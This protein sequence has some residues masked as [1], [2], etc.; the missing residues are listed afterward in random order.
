MNGKRA[1]VIEWSTTHPED[2]QQE[3]RPAPLPSADAVIYELHLRDFSTGPASGIRYRGKYLAFT[4]EHTYNREGKSTGIDHLEEFGITHLHLLPVFD[5]SSVDETDS[6]YRYNWG[7]D[8]QNYNVPEGSYATDAYDPMRRIREFKEM[9]M[10][11]HRAGIRVVMDV[12]YNHTWQ[13]AKSAFERTNPGY[14]FRHTVNGEC[15]DGSGC[16]NETASEQPMMRKFMVKSVCYWMKEYH[17]DGFRFDL[18]G[19]HDM[20]TMNI[21]KEEL[22]KIDPTIFVYGEGWTASDSPLPVEE[23]A[24]KVN[25][26]HMNEVAVFSDD[27]RDALKGSVFEEKQAGFAS[28][29]TAGNIETVKFG[30]VGAVRHPQIDYSQILYADAPYA[31][32]PSQVINYVSCHDDLCLVDKLRLSA[33]EGATEEELIRF[34]KLAQTVIFTSQGVPFMRAG[35]ELFHDKQGVHNSYKSPDG[36]NQIDWT[37]KSIHQDVFNYYRDLIALRKAHPAFRIPTAAGV[38]Q[39]LRFIDTKVPGVIAYTLGEHANGDSWKEI[40]VVFNGKRASQPITIP[41]GSWMVVCRDGKINM[42]GLGLVTGGQTVIPASSA[43]I[44]YR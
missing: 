17:I 35:E 25:A 36:I 24:I 19:V 12:V 6:R 22:V 16:G 41:E 33:P 2:W 40:L 28:G 23:R 7:Y 9:V 29:L 20:E 4:Q 27:L 43:L 10:A 38:Q 14:F 3:E 32:N 31:N 11:L 21:I 13:V 30:I 37:L 26:I 8:P 34:N 44:L 1:A 15:S 18:M 39:H 5:F 42:D